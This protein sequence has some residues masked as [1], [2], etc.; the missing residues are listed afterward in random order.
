MLS[1]FHIRVD[2][3]YIFFGKM[4]VQ[5][6]CPIF[7][8]TVHFIFYFFIIFFLMPI[9]SFL[10]NLLLPLKICNTIVRVGFFFFLNFT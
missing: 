4:S 5:V 3:L 2:H 10:K 1:N 9:F 6:L 7:T 8:W